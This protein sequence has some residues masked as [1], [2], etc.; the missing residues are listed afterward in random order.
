MGE[1]KALS[2]KLPTKKQPIV[3]GYRD[4]ELTCPKGLEL[5]QRAW[6]L[7]KRPACN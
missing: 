7:P 2:L 3:L 5:A 1:E 6:N 4:D